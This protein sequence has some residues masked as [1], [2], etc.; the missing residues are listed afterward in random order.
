M[1]SF[2]SG[3]AQM[4]IGT[5]SD[6]PS[7]HWKSPTASATRY[8]DIFTVGENFIVCFDPGPGVSDTSL[9]FEIAMSPR[10]ATTVTVNVALKDGSS[11]EGKARRASVDSSC[12][13]AYER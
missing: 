4:R 5:P 1:S 6:A 9:P 8:D 3:V 7:R 2:F 11:N 12:V 10:S 13:T